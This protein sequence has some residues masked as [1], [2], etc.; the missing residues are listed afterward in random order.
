MKS[1]NAEGGQHGMHRLRLVT[2]M[3]IQFN[4]AVILMDQMPF[5]LQFSVPNVV[6]EAISSSPRMR[7]HGR[8]RPCPQILEWKH[9]FFLKLKVLQRLKKRRRIDILCLD[10]PSC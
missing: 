5:S 2:L 6:V 3:Y 1:N 7:E 10:T 4:S 8:S 9:A